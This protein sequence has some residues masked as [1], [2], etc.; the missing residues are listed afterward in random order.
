M[1]RVTFALWQNALADRPPEGWS[2]A[3]AGGPGGGSLAPDLAPVWRQ[4]GQAHTTDNCSQT[5][6]FNN[7]PAQKASTLHKH[8]RRRG[9]EGTKGAGIGTHTSRFEVGGLA[10]GRL[11]PTPL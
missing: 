6:G 3:R 8:H 7:S 4:D 11:T 5:G 10:R 9:K 1:S 2:G